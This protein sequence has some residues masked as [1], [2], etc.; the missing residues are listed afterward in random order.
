MGNLDASIAF[1]F[2]TQ[3]NPK[4]NQKKRG[5]CHNVRKVDLLFHFSFN[6][7]KQ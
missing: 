4:R 7:E 5:V 3:P 6:L 1:L 2:P